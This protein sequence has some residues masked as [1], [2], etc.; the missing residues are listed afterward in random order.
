[1]KHSLYNPCIL[2]TLCSLKTYAEEKRSDIVRYKFSF[3]KKRLFPFLDS[4]YLSLSLY[5]Y[6]SLLLHIYLSIYL[7]LA[8]DSSECL[9]G[10]CRIVTRGCVYY[11]NSVLGLVTAGCVLVS[12]VRTRLLSIGG[13]CLLL[14]RN[15]VGLLC[16]AVH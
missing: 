15:K 3:K 11:F 9:R 6:L 16:R 1:M 10:A 12:L 2:N 7:S 5:I 4:L 8:L 14:I 13:Q